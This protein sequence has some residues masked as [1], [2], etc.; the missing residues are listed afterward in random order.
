MSDNFSNNLQ[1]NIILNL[2]IDYGTCNTVIGYESDGKLLHV[3][4]EVSGDVLIPSTI[5][6]IKDEIDA[7]LNASQLQI[8]KHRK[9]SKRCI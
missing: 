9:R 2:S 3:L 1:N 7:N 4:D 6:F 8:N 5:L